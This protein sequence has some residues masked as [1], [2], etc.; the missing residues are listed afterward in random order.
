MRA[1]RLQA[2]LADGRAALGTTIHLS[3]PAVV[4]AAAI[5]GYDWLSLIVEHAPFSLHDVHRHQLA[6]DARGITTLVHIASPD[7]G[8]ILPLLNLG[9]GG[10]VGSH[11]ETRQQAER[12][13]EM[14]L[15]PPL[16]HRGAHAS[17]RATGYGAVPYDEYLETANDGVMVGVVLED[18][19]AIADAGDILSVPGLSIVF[20]GLLDLAQSLGPPSDA[21]T[22]EILE[23]VRSVARI[24]SALGLTMAMS[25]YPFGVDELYAL[26]AR[27]VIWPSTDYAML[28]DAFRGH[29]AH[30]HELLA[31][32]PDVL[33]RH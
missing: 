18:P 19:A 27:M 6:A 4:E 2:A 3:D 1:D 15:F 28:L 7:D 10:I 23:A 33:P 30:A 24:T 17:V 29:I 32:I 26:G 20:V 31:A 16:G 13:V 14:T 9:V 8:R 11:T 25:P 21:R 22:E 5:A 12:L